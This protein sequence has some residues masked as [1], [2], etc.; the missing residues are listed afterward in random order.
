[1]IRRVLVAAV[2]GVLVTLFAAG[3]AWAHGGPIQLLVRGDGGQGIT[4]T[5]TYIRDGH[6][7]DS[8]ITMSYTAVSLSGDTVGPVDLVASAEGQAF[9]VSKEK[10]P[11]GDWTVTVNA[12][13]PSAATATASV[14][15]V[16]LPE[17]GSSVAAPGGMS[18]AV[19]V[20][21]PVAVAVIGVVVVIALRRRRLTTA[22]P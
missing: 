16:A 20:G 17:P 13:K 18:T 5:A 3:P 4:V 1:M 2:L 12:V 21:I 9:Y 19:L 6:A 10:L 15:S 11:L 7:V 22:R 8:E 14:T